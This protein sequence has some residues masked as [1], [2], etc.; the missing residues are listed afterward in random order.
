M[1]GFNL[2]PGCNVSD[3]PG[4]SPKDEE[5]EHFVE[6]ISKQKWAKK[7][8]KKHLNVMLEYMEN[9]GGEAY[10]QGYRSGLRH[11]ICFLG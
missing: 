4:N 3:L 6:E 5:F 10:Q 11:A 1:T 7:F 9:E 2:P 8:K